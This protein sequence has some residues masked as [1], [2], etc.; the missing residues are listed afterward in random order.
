MEDED[1]LISVQLL[2]TITLLTFKLK[3]LLEPRKEIRQ[4]H[5]IGKTLA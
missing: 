1:V 5:P 3:K 4:S 2:T